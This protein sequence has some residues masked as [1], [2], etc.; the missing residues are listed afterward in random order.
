MHRTIPK[1]LDQSGIYILDEAG[2]IV[3]IYDDSNRPDWYD[4]RDQFDQEHPADN[5][6]PED[7]EN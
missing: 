3:V 7:Y 2:V 6:Q 1:C 5:P 4:E